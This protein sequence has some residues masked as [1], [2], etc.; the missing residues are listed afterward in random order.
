MVIINKNTMNNEE[1]IFNG[2][3]TELVNNIALWINGTLSNTLVINSDIDI[4]QYVDLFTNSFSRIEEV[5]PYKIVLHDE[6]KVIYT[7][8]GTLHPIASGYPNLTIT[9]GRT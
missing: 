2:N 6:N 5:D 4:F 3:I 1:M 9:D 8:E 7:G